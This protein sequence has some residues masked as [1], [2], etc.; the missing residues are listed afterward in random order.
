MA[1]RRRFRR[2]QRLTRV[3]R[4]C[5]D[6]QDTPYQTYP[7]CKAPHGKGVVV[8]QLNGQPV[9]KEQ[10][11]GLS[12]PFEHKTEFYSDTISPGDGRAPIPRVWIIGE[13]NAL[14]VAAKHCG[15]GVG[16]LWHSFSA[17]LGRHSETSESCHT[18]EDLLP[19]PAF[20]S[21]DRILWDSSYAFEAP[22]E[23]AARVV[24][25]ARQMFLGE[26]VFLF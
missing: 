25:G 18:G 7:N 3:V 4:D 12:A 6:R 15:I 5:P 23:M 11:L 1:G 17:G 2:F 16:W 24:S 14:I 20:L 8:G 9:P 22:E 13:T 21:V 19:S 10:A 26:F